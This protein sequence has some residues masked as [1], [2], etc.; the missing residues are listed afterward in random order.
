MLLFWSLAAITT[1]ALHFQFRFGKTGQTFK[2]FCIALSYSILSWQFYSHKMLF[3]TLCYVMLGM[4][5]I[6]IVSTSISRLWAMDP[7]EEEEPYHY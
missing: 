7:K 2:A 1:I 6:V 3:L 5:S 4:W